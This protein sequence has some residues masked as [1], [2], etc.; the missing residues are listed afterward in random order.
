MGKRSW[1]S[2]L[3]GVKTPWGE[4]RA[5]AAGERL[6]EHVQPGTGSTDLFGGFSAVHLLDLRSTLYGSVQYRRTDRNEFGYLYGNT[7]LA[8]LGYE[9]K[10]SAR[11]DA[12]L[13]LNGRD[14]GRDEIDAGGEEDP[15]T[16]GVLL[17]LAP[18][19]L[20]DLGKSVVARLAV[21]VPVYDGLNGAQKE[22]TV[23]NFG[24]TATF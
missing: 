13:E 2:L 5:S 9:R 22:K 1:I 6:D 14:A 18:R 3:A 23:L 19:L 21:Q 8:N 24:I 10:L 20:V 11:W 16:G 17:V 15:N 7:F 4:N 12:A